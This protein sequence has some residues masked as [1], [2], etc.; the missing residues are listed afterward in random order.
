MLKDW[1]N[2]NAIN[3]SE[4]HHRPKTYDEC[5]KP[6]EL[7]VELWRWAVWVEKIGRVLFVALIIFGFIISI[8][9]TALTSMSSDYYYDDKAKTAELVFLFFGTLFNW[10]IYALIECALYHILSICIGAF[11]N[12]TQHTRATALLI[13]YSLTKNADEEYN[14]PKSNEKK[15][16]KD[17]SNKADDKNSHYQ[18][19][20]TKSTNNTYTSNDEQNQT[21]STT[22]KCPKCGAVHPYSDEQPK[23]N[24]CGWEL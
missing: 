14:E 11:A 2:Q 9:D 24:N 16:K 13:E 21:N 12:I 7:T 17:A 22:W 23:C 15:N 3:T 8:Y 19:K 20:E 10:A 18:Q 5:V 6:D 1:I 4:K